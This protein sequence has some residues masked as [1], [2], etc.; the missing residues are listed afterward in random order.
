[1]KNSDKKKYQTPKPDGQAYADLVSEYEREE[2]WDYS[3]KSNAQ[4]MGKNAKKLK[5]MK[6]IR[7]VL[8]VIGAVM[9]IYL[10]YFIIALIKGINAREQTTTQEYIII[11][12]D[13]STTVPS[14]QEES[15]VPSTTQST[16]AAKESNT[17]AAA[18]DSTV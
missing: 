4:A 15:T 16:T 8:A 14:T 7:T 6:I 10:G 9:V 1:M 5:R 18:E 11:S 12:E 3:F 17:T 2:M 13:E